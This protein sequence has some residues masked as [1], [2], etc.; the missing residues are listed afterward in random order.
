MA[1][2]QPQMLKWHLAALL[3]V[4]YLLI[5]LST[6]D[7]HSIKLTLDAS[8]KQIFFGG[9][10]RAKLLL[11][12]LLMT[13]RE[14]NQSLLTE[15]L[16]II[17]TAENKQHLPTVRAAKKKNLFFLPKR[18]AC[19]KVNP[20]MHCAHSTNSALIRIIKQPSNVAAASGVLSHSP[21]CVRTAWALSVTE[22][23]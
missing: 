19:P 10:V 23:G 16:I 17:I 8:W 22:K 15:T 12:L 6:S 7:S 1:I 21:A 18:I 5:W 2:R 13:W 4:S 20:I 11:Y 14:H 3:N 9:E